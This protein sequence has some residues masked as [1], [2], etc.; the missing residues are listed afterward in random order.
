[1]SGCA[2]GT[3]RTELSVHARVCWLC[4]ILPP[5]SAPPSV[6]PN[7]VHSPGSSSECGQREVKSLPQ[8]TADIS[9]ILALHGKPTGCLICTTAC[10][11]D[12]SCMLCP[13][14]LQKEPYMHRNFY[15]VYFP[16][17]LFTYPHCFLGSTEK[18]RGSLT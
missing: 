16:C 13:S 12:P 14:P 5:F 7:T 1:M 6:T 11:S 18:Q 15:C 10:S 8:I 4:A 17:V 9:V 2:M 3:A